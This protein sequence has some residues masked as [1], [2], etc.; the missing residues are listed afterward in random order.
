MPLSTHLYN[1]SL[2][3]LEGQGVAK[4]VNE[5]F[6]L[7]TAA[8][9]DGMH[10]AVL[11]MGWF[12]R[13]GIGVELDIEESKRWYRKS[14]RQKEPRAMFSLGEICYDER[15]YEEAFVWFNRAAESG[16]ARSLY[17][18]GMLHWKGR[19]VPENKSLAKKFFQQAAE[20][21]IYEAQRFFAFEI[22]AQTEEYLTKTRAA[23]P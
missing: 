12:Y 11:A 7:N 20:K 18:I 4:D 3:Y 9:A 5:A 13:R 17:W 19:G 8:A 15:D 14:A 10:D 2:K 6:R 16:H 23:L 1:E 21:K 22:F